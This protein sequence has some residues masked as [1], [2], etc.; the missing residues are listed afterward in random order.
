MTHKEV[1]IVDVSSKWRVKMPVTMPTDIVHWL[2]EHSVKDLKNLLLEMHSAGEDI[3]DYVPILE[4]LEAE[5][6]RLRL[7]GVLHENDEDTDPLEYVEQE[8]KEALS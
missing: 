2:R 8:M 3:T 6:K 4:E 7:E 1:E 5:E